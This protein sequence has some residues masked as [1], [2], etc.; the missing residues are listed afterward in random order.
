VGCVPRSKSTNGSRGG[1]GSKVAA[2]AVAG[3]GREGAVAEGAVGDVAVDGVAAGRE[4]AGAPGPAA[5]GA[6]RAELEA[7][8]EP[9]PLRRRL[10]HQ[11]QRRGAELRRG[12]HRHQVPPPR[13]LR[14]RRAAIT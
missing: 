11:A 7:P 10:V 12:G 14:L 3:L 9:P 1:G 4:H 6:G 8:R 13:S 5:A 2:K